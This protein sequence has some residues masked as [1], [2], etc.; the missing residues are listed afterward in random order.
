V[1][2][3]PSV[4]ATEN[5]M[6]AA[7]RTPYTTTIIN[8]AIEPEIMHVG[9]ILEQMG[10]SVSFHAPATVTITGS[11]KLHPIEHTIIPDRL[12]AG[13]F[14]IAAAITGGT[15]TIPN[16]PAHAMHVFLEKLK[17]MG[18]TITVGTGGLGIMLQAHPAPR[19]TSL[20]TMP[21]PGFPTDLQAPMVVAQTVAQGTATIHETVYEARFGYATELQRL[22]AQITVHNG[23]I[24]TIQGVT[25]LTGTTVHGKDIRAAAALCLAGLVAHNET[26]IIGLD[27]IERGYINFAQK[28]TSLGANIKEAHEVAGEAHNTIT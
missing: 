17:D 23:T 25:H 2:E 22:G 9:S 20:R 18:H 10:A 7:A 24:A 16:A 4:G 21:Y 26:T 11:T 15:V 3:Y 12:E 27:H 13:T 19:A 5:I 1:L 14:L 8:A 28:L 6:L